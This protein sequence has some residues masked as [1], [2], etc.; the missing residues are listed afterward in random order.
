V[1]PQKF[2]NNPIKTVSQKFNR[3]PI[4]IVLQKFNRNPIKMVPQKLKR[5]P[6]VRLINKCNL[7]K[8]FI[9]IYSLGF[10]VPEQLE[11]SL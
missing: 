9:A 6:I 2:N 1:V 4:E 7:S 11:T 5:V 3:N 8:L 10:P